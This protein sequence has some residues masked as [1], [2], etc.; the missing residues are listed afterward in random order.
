MGS[1]KNLKL[2]VESFSNTENPSSNVRQWGR[3]LGDSMVFLT[4]F[5]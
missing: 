3:L 5:R 2:A 1:Q 4:T